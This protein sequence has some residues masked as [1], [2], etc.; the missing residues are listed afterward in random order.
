MIFRLVKGFV[1]V[2]LF[3]V[4]DINKAMELK[5]FDELVKIHHLARMS[6]LGCFEEVYRKEYV[7]GSEKLRN[8]IKHQI[9]S[10]HTTAIGELVALA[11]K[12]SARLP[13]SIIL[14]SFDSTQDATKT[15]EILKQ[16]RLLDVLVLDRER[17]KFRDA[18]TMAGGTIT[19]EA[20]HKATF[21]S[22]R[23][24]T[25]SINGVIGE[26]KTHLKKCSG[27]DF[28]LS[29]SEKMKAYTTATPSYTITD[30]DT[31]IVIAGVLSKNVHEA[32]NP[33]VDKVF[34]PCVVKYIEEFIRFYANVSKEMPVSL[35]S[36]ET[37][38]KDKWDGTKEL[39]CF[40]LR[41]F[42]K[43][44]D[45]YKKY[46]SAYVP[47]AGASLAKLDAAKSM[48]F[49]LIPVKFNTEGGK[50]LDAYIASCY[51]ATK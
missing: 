37:I 26:C 28:D 21:A 25:N 27:I 9:Y 31:L 3:F 44:S 34:A 41:G 43:D 46:I 6:A 49:I 38:Y 48:F 12:P 33:L 5:S 45:E 22:I 30:Y 19:N 15:V 36:V 4:F 14:G 24:L 50:I 11:A 2:L 10:G 16:I 13:A 20:P 1:F 32:L 47:A 23:V 51:P 29:L 39:W 17:G 18:I 35:A 7:I 40:T 8:L 42:F